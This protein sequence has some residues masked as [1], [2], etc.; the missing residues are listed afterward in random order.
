[1]GRLLLT[2]AC[3]LHTHTLLVSSDA[4]LH[5][6]LQK[7]TSL[8]GRIL[9]ALLTRDIRLETTSEHL[10]NDTV[11]TVLVGCIRLIFTYA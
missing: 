4:T 6:V 5:A 3:R 2:H 10:V 8:L 11:A 1:M 7:L 9:L